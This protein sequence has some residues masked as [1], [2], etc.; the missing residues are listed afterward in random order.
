L[1]PTS[2]C[3]LHLAQGTTTRDIK[4]ELKLARAVPLMREKLCKDNS[5][6]EEHYDSIDWDSH[7]RALK[8]LH[9]H[10]S[11]LVKYLNNIL[12]V[13]QKVH[14]YNPKYPENCP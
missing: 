5:W 8:Q 4:S 14:K 2:G 3:Q 6:E 13:G 9:N 12:P 1:L 11:T 10:K 7:G